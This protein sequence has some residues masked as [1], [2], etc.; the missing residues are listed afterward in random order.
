MYIDEIKEKI[1][2]HKFAQ[3]FSEREPRVGWAM[4]GL[5]LSI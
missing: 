3:K 2:S 5:G 4:G 1:N